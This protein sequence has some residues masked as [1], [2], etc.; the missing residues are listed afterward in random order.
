MADLNFSQPERRS[1]AIP[2][3]LALVLLAVGLAFAAHLYSGGIIALS[4]LHTDVLPTHTVFRSDS[5]VVGP[6]QTS[7]VLFVASTVRIQNGSSI[8]ISLDGFSCTF[9]DPTGAILAEK[10]VTAQ[11]LPNVEASFPALKPLIVNPLSPEANLNPGQSVQGTIL[12]SLPFTRAQ[13]DAR[14]SAILQVDLYRRDPLT[15]EIP[16]P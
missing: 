4:A 12:F 13:W 7:D 5:I 10:A 3:V 2:I 1:F 14:K 15:A 9:T 11:D 8:P 6:P 16:K